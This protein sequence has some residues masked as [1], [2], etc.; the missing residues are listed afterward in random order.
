MVGASPIAGGEDWLQATAP[1]ETSRLVSRSKRKRE[2]RIHL[3]TVRDQRLT[4]QLSH[5]L[6]APEGP[7]TEPFVLLRRKADWQLDER[8]FWLLH[9][10]ARYRDAGEISRFR[11]EFTDSISWVKP[12]DEPAT[13]VEDPGS[14]SSTAYMV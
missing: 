11:H 2:L 1:F 6:A 3:L 13:V 8:C 9:A 7:L 12:L 4:D 10:M 5:A 14:S